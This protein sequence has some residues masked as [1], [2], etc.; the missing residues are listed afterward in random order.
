LSEIFKA[1]FNKT[2]SL[3]NATT[4]EFVLTSYKAWQLYKHSNLLAR[5]MKK[6]IVAQQ[7]FA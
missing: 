7:Y 6:K 1:K 4:S 3:K 2:Q 5:D